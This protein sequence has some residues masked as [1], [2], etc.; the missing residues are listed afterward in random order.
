[1]TWRRSIDIDGLHHG[2]APIPQASLVGNLLISSGISGMDPASG[3]IPSD[4]AMQVLLLFANVEA[5]VEAAGGRLT[6]I[7]KCTF[8]VRDRAIR[9]EVDVH[10]LRCFPDAASRP[11]RHLLVQALPDPVQIQCEVIA[12]IKNTESE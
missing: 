11:A 9:P 12:Y 4:P 5:I 7:V 10:W 3:D 2:G 6:D 8:F 1:M